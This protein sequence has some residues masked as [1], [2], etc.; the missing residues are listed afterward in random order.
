MVALLMSGADCLAQPAITVDEFGLQSAAASLKGE[1]QGDETA[2]TAFCFRARPAPLCRNFAVTDFGLLFGV[3]RTGWSS[4]FADSPDVHS[5]QVIT[6]LGAMRNLGRHHAIGATWFISLAE[7]EFSTGPAVR[8]RLWLDERQ[9]IDVGVGTTVAPDSDSYGEPRR[10]SLL[11]VVRYSP[12]PWFALAVRPEVW[13]HADCAEPE[14]G[15]GCASP[16]GPPDSAAD[17]GK[18][19]RTANTTRILAGIEISE[20]PGAVLGGI[21]LGAVG[22]VVLLVGAAGG[23]GG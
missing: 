5:A 20:K 14:S 18:R 11:G 9:S 12:A 16:L 15:Y 1:A 23:W 10:G 2:S 22:L 6:E 4:V 8:Y 3:T 21:W 13:H 19:V 17:P 7:E